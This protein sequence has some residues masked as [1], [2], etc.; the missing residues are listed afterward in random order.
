MSSR[1]KRL[2]AVN[3][4][5]NDVIDESVFEEPKARAS[6]Q[7]KRLLPTK[8][9]AESGP[10]VPYNWQPAP[11]P[12]DAFSFK[13]DLT[14]AYIDVPQQ[15]LVCPNMDPAKVPFPNNT[16]DSSEFTLR[17][18]DYIYMISEPPGEPYYIGRIMG[19]T[20][21]NRDHEPSPQLVR[22]STAD[23]RFKIQWF[24]RPRD[25]SKSTL[26]SRLLFAS[27]HTDSCPL[28]SFRGLVTVHHKQE[29]EQ[30]KFGEPTTSSAAATAA[31]EAYSM[32]PNCFYFDKLFDRYMIKFYDIIPTASLL[33]YLDNPHNNSTNFLNA[34]HKRYEF[35]FMEAARTKP[36]ISSFSSKELCHCEVCAQWC[37]PQDLVTCATCRKFYHMLC[38]DPPLLKKPSRGFSWLCA[39]CNK[40]HEIEY[41][42]KRMLMLLHDNK[43]LNERELSVELST[44]TSEASQ[45]ETE[46][47]P[48][49]PRE[50]TGPSVPKY[51]LV[52]T[53]FLRRDSHNSF[54]QRRLKEEWC[55]RY[56]GMH[57]RLEDGV[58]LDDRLPYPRASTRLGAR[59]Q[60]ANVPEFNGH[61]IV[62]YDVERAP[63]VSN[64]KKKQKKKKPEDEE[65]E[66]ERK[67]VVPKEYVDV[68]R[69]EYPEWLQPRPKG[70]IERGVDD[71]EGVTL[72]LLWKPPQSDVAEDFVTLDKYI[73][74]CAPY[75]TK[76]EVLPTSPNFMDAILRY[77]LEEGN[78]EAALK[79]VGQ[80]TRKTLK[81][82]TFSKEEV[83]RFEAGVKQYGSELYPTSKLVKTQPCSMVVR[84]YYL[85]KKTKNGKLIWGNFEGRMHKKLQNIKDEPKTKTKVEDSLVD[86]NDDSAYEADKVLASKKAFECKHCATRVSTQWYRVT[87][88]DAS[89]ADKIAVGLCF[90][91]ARL[92][93]RYA[94]HWEDP[95]EVQR[96]T[97]KSVGGWKKRVEYEL[98]LDAELITQKAEEEDATLTYDAA[99]IALSTVDSDRPK[100]EESPK[101]RKLP[102][103]ETP[104]PKKIKK[105]PQPIPIP[106]GTRSR[107]AKPKPAPK[108]KAEV[109]APAPKKRKKPEAPKPKKEPPAK[110][111]RPASPLPQPQ[112]PKVYGDLVD[113]G[114]YQHYVLELANDL[115]Q[116]AI[117]RLTDLTSKLP[118]VS[119]PVSQPFSP[120]SRKCT[121]CHDPSDVSEMLICANCGVNA[122]LSCTDV[123]APPNTPMP[124]HEWLCAPCVN[125]LRPLHLNHY[126]CALCHASDTNPE[127]AMLG[128]P[129]VSPDYL[130]P[131]YDSGRWCH[132]VCALF[133]KNVVFRNLAP[134]THPKKLAD[135][136][137]EGI[138]DSL[139]TSFHI[140]SLSKVFI[141]HF[142]DACGICNTRGGALIKCDQCEE[143]KGVHPTCAQDTP[144]YTLG[145]A[146]E[147]SSTKDAVQIDPDTLGKLSAV[148]RC[149]THSGGTYG[150]R[151]K[152]KRVS[153]RD[154]RLEAKPLIQ[155]FIEDLVR[156]AALENQTRASGPRFQAQ[157]YL[158]MVQQYGGGDVDAKMAADTTTCRY[159]ASS[160]SPMWWGD[161]QGATCQACHH[162]KE[163][164]DDAK[165]TTK[166]LLKVL[167]EPL[168]GSQFG[169]AG[170][171]DCLGE[172]P[173]PEPS[174]FSL[175]NILAS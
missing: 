113:P 145:F 152:A 6:A 112:R 125:D 74:Q 83:K 71:G 45:T 148:I 60:A 127:L 84:F 167:H 173:P 70:Y 117:R 32:Q 48:T 36:F 51:E 75:A 106:S 165:E 137:A 52:A 153:S 33:Q 151:T 10:V 140:E 25:I 169:L 166:E 29:V 123:T 3:K 13:L 26:D 124:I 175:R 133:S 164:I 119:A 20:R 160:L 94:V 86:P 90:R 1:P 147:S 108:P 158:D 50:A 141:H 91:C 103:V 92:W 38:L 11:G 102:K 87:G 64:G 2:A 31:L 81:E 67:L 150:L 144:G 77:Y 28:Q 101:K 69:S 39:P 66:V 78:A 16:C 157:N 49:P 134:H 41:Q 58:D 19:F 143:A 115:Q 97:T 37:D 129:H 56:L 59:H 146:L 18:G 135:T 105:E 122:H 110:K 107:P 54:E 96:K 88:L 98:V 171:S 68:P 62:Y 5:Y 82:P 23:Y 53:D 126:S 42:K 155:L 34:L 76:L 57:S 168:S 100:K 159:C 47:S 4:S 172:L 46:K 14:D 162:L 8:P 174:N 156:H 7:R 95:V 21:K 116:A 89:K 128:L 24:Y 35:V 114:F 17:K 93:R 9:Q 22:E 55:M 131:V 80:L 149:P 63:L 15:T 27:M 138:L 161:D 111:P 136:S 163:E 109:P 85:W 104:P 30:G 73:E 132:L 170:E 65:T 12:A 121:V 139:H 72:T 40:I 44:L 43:S 99:D 79:K 130:K 142:R 154:V 61:R 118:E 120:E